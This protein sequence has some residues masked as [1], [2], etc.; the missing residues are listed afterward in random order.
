ML[1]EEQRVFAD[2]VED[3]LASAP[4]LHYARLLGP[5]EVKSRDRTVYAQFLVETSPAHDLVLAIELSNRSFI[6]QVNGMSFIRK[7]G[8]GTRFEWWVERRCRDLERLVGGDLRLVHHRLLTIPISSTLEAG[9]GEKWHRIGARENGWLAFLS[10]F[11]PYS[12]LMTGQKSTVYPDWFS[13]DP[14]PLS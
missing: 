6:V 5:A 12:F 8:V 14:D 2:C 11:I 4:R 9:N 1:S 3:V 7:R 10:F 13:A